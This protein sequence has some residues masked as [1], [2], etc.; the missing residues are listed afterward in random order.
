MGH[1]YRRRI[2]EIEWIS[3]EKIGCCRAF[4]IQGAGDEVAVMVFAGIQMMSK[5]K[6]ADC[7]GVWLGMWRIDLTR[8]WVRE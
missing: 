7:Q 2:A 4:G 5:K 8:N 6:E 1:I 3:E